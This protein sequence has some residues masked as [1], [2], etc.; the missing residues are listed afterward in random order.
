MLLEIEIYNILNIFPNS[1]YKIYFEKEWKIPGEIQ[2]W[3]DLLFFEEVDMI[4]D[5]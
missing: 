2:K 4:F 3:E 1:H 5:K